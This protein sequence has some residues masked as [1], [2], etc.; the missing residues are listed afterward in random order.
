MRIDRNQETNVGGC[1]SI[2]EKD[3]SRGVMVAWCEL[4]D[5]SVRRE[6]KREKRA[7]VPCVGSFLSFRACA[8]CACLAGLAGWLTCSVGGPSLGPRWI[9]LETLGPRLFDGSLHS[10]LEGEAAGW[11]SH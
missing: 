8:V 3:D 6:G 1:V 2:L 5:Q 9:L 7:Y 4:L 11:P 10:S